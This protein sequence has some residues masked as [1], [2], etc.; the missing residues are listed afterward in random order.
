M[1]APLGS[2]RT[3]DFLH[4]PPVGM[5]QN[6]TVSGPPPEEGCCQATYPVPFDPMTMGPVVS[7]CAS[8]VEILLVTPCG[9][10]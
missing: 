9:A 3:I 5:A 4:V 2:G 1:A 10:S 7:A 6:K 8:S